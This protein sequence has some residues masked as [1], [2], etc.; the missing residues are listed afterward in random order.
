MER[1]VERLVENKIYV[2]DVIEIDERDIGKYPN[3]H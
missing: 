2:D 1:K 3:A